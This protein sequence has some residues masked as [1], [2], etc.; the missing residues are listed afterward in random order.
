MINSFP[1]NRSNNCEIT[2]PND[3][4]AIHNKGPSVCPITYNSSLHIPL[5]QHNYDKD[6]LYIMLEFYGHSFYG[7][8]FMKSGLIYSG[9]IS[10][11]LFSNVS[12]VCINITVE[13]SINM[14][15]NFYVHWQDTQD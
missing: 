6:Q 1:H 9:L 11:K 2:S 10:F 5:T 4:C 12:L 7:N 13:R 14:H 8:R 3:A 15:C